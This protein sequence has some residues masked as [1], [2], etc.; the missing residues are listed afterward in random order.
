MRNL[1]LRD[2]DSLKKEQRGFG[3]N[4]GRWQKFF[5]RPGDKFKTFDFV[6]DGE[7]RIHISEV[8]YSKYD[9]ESLLHFYN[10]VLIRYY[11]QM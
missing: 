9:D 5:V 2:L 1:I 4:E 11:R 10:A 6:K 3:R 8:D 7:K